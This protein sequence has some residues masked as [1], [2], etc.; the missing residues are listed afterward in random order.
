MPIGTHSALL[1]DPQTGLMQEPVVSIPSTHCDSYPPHML[2]ELIV[3]HCI[4][5]PPGHFGGQDVTRFFIGTLD[6]S[7]HDSYADLIGVRVSSHFFI[8]RTGKI[9]QYVSTNQRAWHAG[10]SRWRHRTMCNDFSIGIELEGTDRTSF[11][12]IQYWMAQEVILALYPHYPLQACLAHSEI[13]PGRKTD[14]GVCFDWSFFMQ[15]L[16]ML[17]RC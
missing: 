9:I 5:L 6:E 3:M 10:V 8:R 17:E 2:V 4:S 7:T 14:P 1:L 13:A 11:E 12:A 15:R 16:P